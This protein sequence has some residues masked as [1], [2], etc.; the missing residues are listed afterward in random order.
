M[1]DNVY[2]SAVMYCITSRALCYCDAMTV[3]LALLIRANTRPSRNAPPTR[4][5][6]LSIRRGRQRGVCARA[7]SAAQTRENAT[8][9]QARRFG[10]Q[11]A[12]NKNKAPRAG[13]PHMSPI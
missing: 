13:P 1:R 5:G 4:R 12:P 11:V 7:S 3:E 10:S 2:T 8:K 6:D 9:P